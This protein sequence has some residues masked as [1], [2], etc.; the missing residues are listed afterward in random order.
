MRKL[1]LVFLFLPI[2]FAAKAQDKKPS[3]EETIQF[4][5]NFMGRRSEYVWISGYQE[6]KWTTYIYKTYKDVTLNECIFKFSV[7]REGRDVSFV[8]NTDKRFGVREVS[9]EVD[10][11]KCERIQLVEPLSH[12]DGSALTYSSVYFFAANGEKLFKNGIEMTDEISINIDGILN[13]E[14]QIFKAFNH[15]R[16][17]CGA[18]EPIKF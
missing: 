8:R 13:Y 16:K 18:P 15:L 4:I 11:S 2:A 3:K 1:V 7:L 10:L 6:D 12:K 9:F 5:K 17:L 14:S